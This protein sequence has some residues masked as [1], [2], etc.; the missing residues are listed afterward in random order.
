[1]DSTILDEQPT[2]NGA[3]RRRYLLPR[4]IRVFTWIFLI[5]GVLIP[6]IFIHGLTGGEVSLAIYG[7]G[8]RDVFS[9]LWFIIAALFLFKG[10]V[11]WGLWTE[12][13]WAINLAIIDA[14]L[15]ISICLS[16]MTILPFVI[17]RD[18]TLFQ[19]RLELFVLIPYL[20]RLLKVK[21]EW[22]AMENT[23]P[24]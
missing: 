4:W 20:L 11:A 19:L 1:M 14:V 2:E 3:D 23:Q 17:Y 24:Q 12:K 18:G 8:A 9:V 15:G 5:M 21:P 6:V 7:L 22:L 13:T 16:L 10:V